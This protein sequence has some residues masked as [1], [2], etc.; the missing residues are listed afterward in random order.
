M[1]AELVARFVKRFGGQ[2]TVA[3]DLRR[4]ADGFSITVLFGPSGCGKTTTLRCLAGLER[5]E[6]GRIALGATPWFDAARRVCLTPQQRDIGYL[7]QEYALF[8]HLTV[9]G[10]IAYGLRDGSRAARRRQ[11]G[12]MLALFRL[13]G[14]DHRYADQLSG[15]EQQRVGLARALVRRPRLLLLDEPL[16]ALDGPTREQLRPELR[17]LLAAFGIPV[18]LVTHDW[19]E[20]MALADHVIVLDRGKVRQQ[21]PVDDVF[22]RPADLDVARIVGID[23]LLPGDVVKVEAGLATVAVAG[24]QWLAPAPAQPLDQ[25]HV[26]IRAEAVVLEKPTSEADGSCNLLRGVIKTLTPEGALVR[27]GLD[28]GCPLVALVTKP[29]CEDLSLQEGKPITVWLDVSSLHLIA[30]S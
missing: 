19:I 17:R 20:A 3:A 1:S 22:N 30:R 23:N 15:G 10:N 5:P 8:P 2:A 13:T 18:V 12:E 28:C 24:T 21:G 29:A 7:F 9:A 27:V 25:V 4:P 6:E 14:L 11:V 16:S 26:C